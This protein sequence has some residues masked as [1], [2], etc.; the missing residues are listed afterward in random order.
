MC[1]L[2]PNL[3]TMLKWILKVLFAI[4]FVLSSI[5]VGVM[6]SK[7]SF[8]DWPYLIGALVFLVATILVP[9]KNQTNL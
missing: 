2:K 5:V 7:L 9:V 4:G 1:K 6:Y 3:N 8:I